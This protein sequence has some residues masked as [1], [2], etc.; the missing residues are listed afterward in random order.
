MFSLNESYVIKNNI[1]LNHFILSSKSWD[2][3]TGINFSVSDLDEECQNKC[4][5]DFGFY[6]QLVHIL[7]ILSGFL[8]NTMVLS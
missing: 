4:T 8:K 3:Y 6:I 1:S 7:E 2:L 5:L